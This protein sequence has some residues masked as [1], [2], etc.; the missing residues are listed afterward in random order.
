[1][2][3]VDHLRLAI[4][5][6]IRNYPDLEED[7]ML[8][9]DMLD[10]ETD[11]EG[12]LT[13]L[14]Q[15]VDNN[16]LMVSAITARTHELAARKKRFER[17]V[18]FLR[19]LMLQVLQTADLKKYELAEATLSQRASQPAIVGEPD[20]AALPADLCRVTVEPDRV[21]IREALLAHR[22]VPG[23]ALSNSPPVL[24]INVK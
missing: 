11:I 24:S 6:L 12:V 10:A 23:L 19:S 5:D 1:M 20:V 15:A 17:R 13:A 3:N 2:F 14:F 7:E 8:R 22:E 21:K 9:A 4:E 18:E 16:K